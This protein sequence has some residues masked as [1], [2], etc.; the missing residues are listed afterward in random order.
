VKEFLSRAGRSFTVKDVDV[1]PRA[2]D[3]LVAL[4]VMTIPATVVGGRV[5]LGFDEP[6]LRAALEDPASSS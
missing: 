3:E 4:G 5:I 6:A 2:Y 1:D